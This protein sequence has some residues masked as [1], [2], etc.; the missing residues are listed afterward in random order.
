MPEYT[1]APG[2]L[3]SAVK[4]RPLSVNR[5]IF[6]AAVII[7][8]LTLGVKLV[9]LLKE[10]TVAATFGAGD[11]LDAFLI[12]LLLPAY[13]MRLVSGSFNAALI[14]VYIQVREKEGH[15]AAQRLFSGAV[16]FTGT[17]LII[18]TAV[19]AVVGPHLL[20]F[21]AS[22][23]SADKLRLTERLFY[24]LLP[25]MVTSG[26][27]SNY[28]S[29]INAGER[30]ALPAVAPVMVPLTITTLLLVGGA[31]WDVY[32]LAVGTVAGFTLQLGLLA[33][34]L[35][36]QGWSLWPRWHGFEPALRRVMEQYLP[37]LAGSTLMG[38]TWLV[39]QSI[40]TRLAPGSVAVLSYG[41]NLI[42][43][44][45]SIGSLALGTALLPFYSKMVAAADWRGVRHTLNTYGRL[46][47]LVTV[48][49][50]IALFLL[51]DSLVGLALQRGRF[52]PDDTI[53]VSRV[54]QMYALQIPFFSLSILVVR[55]L[56]SLR[57]NHILMWGTV[58][59]FVLNL[60]LDLALLQFFGVAG[61]ALSTALVYMAAC[62][63]L[64]W[65]LSRRLRDAAT[66]KLGWPSAPDTAPSWS[67]DGADTEPR[68][69]SEFDEH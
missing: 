34:F 59:S 10:I 18:A 30:F 55:L 68:G 29:I 65:M 50:T 3:G 51:S 27:A 14:P 44:V 43:P 13:V 25:L 58:I 20:P 22:G 4:A 45:L 69:L 41:H 57:A 7:G 32:S 33:W 5:R 52:T 36:R 12:A 61:V 56:S 62:A 66:G 49:L 67:E 42:D 37:M 63:F 60:G 54:L 31:R 2:L 64:G 26:V 16:V 28:E 11:V 40:A 35:H 53:A 48:P 9:S 21:I 17:L 19:L 8:G 39:D 6:R 24:V 1:A 46:T 15:A 23:F 47:L 38:S